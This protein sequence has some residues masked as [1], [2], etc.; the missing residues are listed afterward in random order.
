MYDREMPAPVPITTPDPPLRDDAIALRPW[1]EDDLEAMVAMNR[2]PEVARFTRVPEPYTDADARAWLA[3]QAARL[4]NGDGLALAIVTDADARPLGT[5]GLRVDADDRDI[6]ELNYIV[7]PWARGRGIATGAA[8]LL[9]AWALREWRLG[10]LQLTTFVD[11]AASQV[12]AERAGFQREA[13][14]RSW[15]EIKG[16]RADLVMYSRL[17]GAA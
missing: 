15:D 11:N 16:Q 13:V 2:D 10:R 6:A 14:L 8:R 17:P 3:F 12:V 9:A 1:R 5:V 7:A 4:R